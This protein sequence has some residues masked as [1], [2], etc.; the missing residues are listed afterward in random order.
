MKLHILELLSLSLF[1]SKPTVAAKVR[2]SP[3]DDANESSSYIDNPRRLFATVSDAACI[4]RPFTEY[5]DRGCNGWKDVTQ[6]ECQQKCADHWAPDECVPEHCHAAVYYPAGGLCHLYEA[7]EC[8]DLIHTQGGITM[9]D[10]FEIQKYRKDEA[11]E[12]AVEEAED[13]AERAHPNPWKEMGTAL[14]AV[15]VNLSNYSGLVSD[16][17]RLA[18]VSHKFGEIDSDLEMLYDKVK[19]GCSRTLPMILSASLQAFDQCQHTYRRSIK[20]CVSI[21]MCLLQSAVGTDIPM[22]AFTAMMEQVTR[23]DDITWPQLMAHLGREDPTHTKV[24]EADMPQEYQCDDVEAVNP[25]ANVR[26]A[27]VLQMESHH[28]QGSSTEAILAMS[29]AFRQAAVDTHRI[30]DAH[31]ANTSMELTA[32]YLQRTWHPLCQQLGC[33]ASNMHDVFVASHKQT[34]ALLQTN[35]VAHVR[36]EIRHRVKMDLRVQRFI[37][38]HGH[39]GELSFY[40]PALTSSDAAARVY[41]EKGRDGVL[42]VVLPTV[43]GLA[44]HDESRVLRLFDMVE[45]EKFRR[46]LELEEAMEQEE[47]ED[48]RSESMDNVAAALGSLDDDEEQD[49]HA[50]HEDE[51]DEDDENEERELHEHEDHEHEEA[52]EEDEEGEKMLA[53]QHTKDV[54]PSEMALMETS[55]EL[56]L[57]ED[58]QGDK[59]SRRSVGYDDADVVQAVVKWA[60]KFFECFG[61][62]SKWDAVGYTKS[63][64]GN[65]GLSFGFSGG[66]SGSIQE[67]VKGSAISSGWVSIGM[68]LSAGTAG[69]WWWAGVGLSGSVTCGTGGS[70]SLGISVGAI[71]CG[72]WDVGINPACPFDLSWLGVKCQG[73][74]GGT[75]LVTCCGV[76]L[77]SGKHNCR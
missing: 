73:S 53:T 40:R 33:D 70:C 3:P 77:I 43:E 75:L 11:E 65:F 21:A 45:F 12:S 76:D 7:V 60:Q 23:F 19:L 39:R 48:L 50:E 69:E 10:E 29:A 35:A 68:G 31:G 15:L 28:A 16:K 18:N 71:G 56:G 67:L 37:A 20:R 14:P 32:H 27:S 4:G 34:M 46:Q 61:Q 24:G 52:S 6:A 55:G 17:N 57:A 30:L 74:R 51:D 66:H 47:E 63:F 44:Q 25:A 62:Y 72:W 1:L 22:T 59:S 8:V 42:G 26:K 13:A 5:P 9:L 38:E 2:A 49:H 36:H 58:E 41:G 54:R 64:G